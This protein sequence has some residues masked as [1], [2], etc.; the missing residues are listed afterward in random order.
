MSGILEVV[1]RLIAAT[2]AHDV[3]GL[4]ECFAPEYLNETPAHPQRGFAG[5][6]QVRQ[7]WTQIFGGVPDV[8]AQVVSSAVDGNLAWTEW[9]M[10]GTRRDG[11]PHSMA[12]VII[13]EVR[14]EH[15]VTARFYLEPV[16]RTTGDVNAA[17]ERA[18][19]TPAS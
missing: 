12:G 7:N 13:F 11:A 14:D 8:T 9:T 15:I 6:D 17:A 2:N 16:E 3:E 5:R 4:V 10:S 19:Q 1:N 18:T